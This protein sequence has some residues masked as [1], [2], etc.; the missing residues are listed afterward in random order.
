M[1]KNITIKFLS[2]WHIGSGLGDGYRTDAKLVRN[3]FGLPFIPGRVLKGALREGAKRL[4][5]CRDDLKRAEIV[6]FG[7]RDDE[8]KT[9]QSGI[10]SISCGEVSDELTNVFLQETPSI[11]ELLVRDMLTLRTQ[12]ALTEDKLTKKGSLRNIECGI[13][14]LEFNAE[15]SLSDSENLYEQIGKGCNKEWIE[16]YFKAV[17]AS[18]KSIGG[19][20]S[21]GLGKC[22]VLINHEK[23]SNVTL[24]QNLEL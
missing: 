8:V 14:G 13:P 7:T 21:R 22:E 11:R 10:I 2:S 23:L 20:R 12:T 4:S 16:A 1:I 17:L 15:I 24:P 3:S 5:S 18:V 9:N 19:D 6:I